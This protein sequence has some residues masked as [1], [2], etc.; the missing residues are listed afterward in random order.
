M[1]VSDLQGQVKQKEVFVGI[2]TEKLVSVSFTECQHD[3]GNFISQT[4][5]PDFTPPA[6][7]VPASWTATDIFVSHV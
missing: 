5:S 2:F 1:A 7:I 3:K 6:P 4:L